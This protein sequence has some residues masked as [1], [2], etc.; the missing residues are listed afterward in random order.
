LTDITELYWTDYL[1]A[2]ERKLYLLDRHFLAINC[3]KA[4]RT[5]TM[6][7]VALVCPDCGE[8]HYHF[9]SCGHRFCPTCGVFA[10]NKWAKNVLSQLPNIKHYHIVFTLPAK[11]RHLS[12]R[13]GDKLH[14]LLFVIAHKVLQEWFE[15]HGLKCG[16]IAVLH[17]AGSDLK[18]HP[19]VHLIVSA[20]GQDLKTG[21]IIELKSDYLTSHKYLAN[22]FRFYFNQALIELYD[23]NHLT[24]RGEYL[25]RAYF[26]NFIKSLNEKAW[27]V[28]IEKPLKDATDIVRYVARYTRRACISEYRIQTI[29]NG[30]IVFTFNDYKNTPKGQYPP[31]QGLCTLTYV[32]FFDRLLQH[33]PTPGFQAV[34][35]YGLYTGQNLKTIPPQYK[36]PQIALQE[37]ES[38]VNIETEQEIDDPSKWEMDYERCVHCG[39]KCLILEV[40]TPKRLGNKPDNVI[41]WKKNKQ[42]VD[43]S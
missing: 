41:K 40:F 17:T 31:V 38:T 8:V 3:I 11:L 34:R 27:I 33:V 16:I 14:H 29:D 9:H 43:S 6:G 7:G 18:Y 28:G 25:K 1:A 10:T 12:R 19:H 2:Q 5:A 22:K 21:E 20:G 39:T 23:N 35:R 32:Q 15:K 37:V 42:Y 26:M 13:N 4:C 24:V 30:K 36:L